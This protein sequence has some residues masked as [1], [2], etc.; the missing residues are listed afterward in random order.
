[1]IPKNSS[2][3]NE[4]RELFCKLKYLELRCYEDS[5]IYCPVTSQVLKVH[6]SFVEANIYCLAVKYN[7]RMIPKIN[8]YEKGKKW[9]VLFTSLF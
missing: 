2:Y 1:M 6:L 3:E 7:K 5:I 4:K 9:F 8:R